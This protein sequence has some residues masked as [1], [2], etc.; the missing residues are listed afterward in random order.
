MS[1]FSFSGPSLTAA[2]SRA[3]PAERRDLS[4][5]QPRSKPERS[6]PD[7]HQLR[8][9]LG[10]RP[11]VLLA[12][13]DHDVRTALAELLDQ[14]GYEVRTVVDGAEL[15]DV[16]GRA[17]LFERDEPPP[18]IIISDIRMPGFNGL[19]TME[20]LRRL[21][22]DVRIVVITA[23]GDEEIRRRVED[24]RDAAF[25]HKPI[26]LDRLEEKLRELLDVS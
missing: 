8:Q 24:L 3:R 21:G 10:R 19:H 6:I 1:G 26:D 11:R 5:A 13:D 17:F 16:I 7:L 4:T 2:G 15:L 23:F 14:E 25:F 9:R 22:H 20:S 18:D 12:E